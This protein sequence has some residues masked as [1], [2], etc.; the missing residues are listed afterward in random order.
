MDDW[1]ISVVV[2]WTVTFFSSRVE[3]E[4]LSLPDGLLARTRLKDITHG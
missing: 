1:P 4:I 2:R 3:T